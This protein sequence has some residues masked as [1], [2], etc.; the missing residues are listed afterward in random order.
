MANF[1]SKIQAK[2]V[3]ILSL[4]VVAVT[5]ASCNDDDEQVVNPLPH[6]IQKF[7]SAY[8]PGQAVASYD[9]QDGCYTVNLYNSASIEFD[10]AMAWVKVDG[11]GGTLPQL[12]L[13]DQLPTKLYE[14][15]ELNN[16]LDEVFSMSRASNVYTLDVLD[17][18]ITYDATAD[19]F[20]DLTNTSIT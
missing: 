17:G 18:L 12:L 3:F 8:F 7:I 16:T 15:L 6:K 5:F 11:H 2:L 10:T 13:Y 14:Y 20:G 1:I 4:I 19:T 9:I